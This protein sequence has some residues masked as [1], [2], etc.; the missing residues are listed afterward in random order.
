MITR[1]AFV[2]KIASEEKPY[3]IAEVRSYLQCTQNAMFVDKKQV[4]ELIQRSS[5][6]LDELVKI[7]SLKE[8]QVL[9][10]TSAMGIELINFAIEHDDNVSELIRRGGLERGILI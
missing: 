4:N 8:D 7:Y 10:N 5:K 3:T 2:Y 6:K 9:D 1:S